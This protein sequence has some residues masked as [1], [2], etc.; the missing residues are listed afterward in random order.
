MLARCGGRGGFP[1]LVG[2]SP[3]FTHGLRQGAVGLVPSGAHLVGAQYQ[4]MYE[5]AM[6][7]RWDDVERLQAE[8]DAVVTAY[9]KGRTMG[10]GLAVLKAILEK[11]GLCG[12]TMLPPLRDHVGDA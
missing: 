5:A 6:A 10:Q 11:R 7:E 12:R 1:V 4:A 9:L 3:A 8:T 2:S